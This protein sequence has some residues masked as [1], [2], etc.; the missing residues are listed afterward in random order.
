MPG[1]GIYS[2]NGRIKSQGGQWQNGQAYE[3]GASEVI[4]GF[5][6]SSLYFVDVRHVLAGAL[7]RLFRNFKRVDATCPETGALGAIGAGGYMQFIGA[8]LDRSAVDVPSRFAV[9]VIN[10]QSIG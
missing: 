8:S 7:G 9:L 1:V 5:T 3:R 2:G 4:H 6:I 10:T